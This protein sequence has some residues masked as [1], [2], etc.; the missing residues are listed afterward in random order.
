MII[1]RTRPIRRAISTFLV[2][3]GEVGFWG[4]V[5]S[6]TIL[7]LEL[8]LRISAIVVGAVFETASAIFFASAG[9]SETTSALKTSVPSTLVN[10]ILDLSSEAVY[11]L[12]SVFETAS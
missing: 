11:L 4:V 8:L 1:E 7:S 10:L 3:L 2:T 6:S 9:L 12:L 5:A